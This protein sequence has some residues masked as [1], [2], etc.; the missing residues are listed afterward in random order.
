MEEEE[1]LSERGMVGVKRERKK[2]GYGIGKEGKG[3]FYTH[4]NSTFYLLF[5]FSFLLFFFVL[6]ETIFCFFVFLFSH[7]L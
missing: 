7:K 1:T 5:F 4:P 2:N 6:K 3:R